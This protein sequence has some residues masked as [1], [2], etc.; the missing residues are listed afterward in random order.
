MS[1]SSQN[2]FRYLAKRHRSTRVRKVTHLLFLLA[3]ASI[4]A[5]AS[6]GTFDRKMQAG[7]FKLLSDHDEKSAILSSGDQHFQFARQAGEMR[8]DRM[9]LKD[10]LVLLEFDVAD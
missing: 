3:L 1:G 2:F 6:F 8:S 10:K 4:S 7:L 5:S 9:W